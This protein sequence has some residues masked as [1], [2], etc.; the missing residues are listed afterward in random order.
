MTEA[1]GAHAS[2]EEKSLLVPIPGSDEAVEIPLSA[3]PQDS[4]EVLDVL[5]AENAPLKLWR[6]VARAY[7]AKVGKGE[8][9]REK[10][11]RE[12]GAAIENREQRG[13]YSGIDG[14]RLFFFFLSLTLSPLLLDPKTKTKNREWPSSSS[15]SS[16]RGPPRTPRPTSARPR[17]ASAPCC[18]SPRPAST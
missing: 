12:R 18:R 2:A 5:R 17:A 8:K 3:L 10:G 11:E 6:D 7:L 9:E 15:T 14:D 4:E 1:N 13:W 16:R